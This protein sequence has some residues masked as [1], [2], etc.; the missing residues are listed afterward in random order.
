M[1]STLVAR[2]ILRGATKQTIQNYAD[3]A[4][5]IIIRGSPLDEAGS[6]GRGN[7]VAL[8]QA[9]RKRRP[10]PKSASVPPA[11]NPSADG[12]EIDQASSEQ[13]CEPC[14]PSGDAITKAL[15][16]WLKSR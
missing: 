12:A 5:E 15:R 13:G 11:N 6:S 9:H 3:A 14:P 4:D 10:A 7:L 2:R 1:P 8:A 16:R